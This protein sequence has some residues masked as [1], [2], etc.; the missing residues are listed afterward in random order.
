VPRRESFL[1]RR[2]VLRGLLLP[3]MWLFATQ[4]FPTS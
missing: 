4:G 1:R 3:T 2:L